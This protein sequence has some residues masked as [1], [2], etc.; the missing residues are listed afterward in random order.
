MIY[1]YLEDTESTYLLEPPE[2]VRCDLGDLCK[3]YIT[4]TKTRS[5]P[6]SASQLWGCQLHTF[7]RLLQSTQWAQ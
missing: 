3:H 5:S 6:T 4:Y 1:G 2:A 7:S